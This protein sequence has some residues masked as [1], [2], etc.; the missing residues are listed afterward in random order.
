MADDSIPAPASSGSPSSRT[1]GGGMRWEP[2]T[3]AELQ[4]LMPGYTIEK[5]LG[6]GGMGAV[7]RGV[8]TNLDRTVAIKILPPGVEQEDPSFAERFKNEA[9][10][11]AKLAHPGVV[12]VYDFGST[13]AGQ[14][15][16]VMEYVDGSDV[17]Q[18]LKE[19]GRLPPE[20]A[21][22][23]TAHVLDALGAAHKL[24]IV[25]RDIKPANILINMAGAVKVADFGLAKI[26]DPGG[27]GL[28][29]TGFS[30]GTP[31]FVSPEALMLGSQVD[32]RADLY[33][34]GVMLYQMLTG[35]IPRGA[36]KPASVL[37]STLDPRYDPI[38]TKAMQH[39]REERYQNS[40]EMRQ[41]LDVILT[42]PYVAPEATSPVAAVPAPQGEAPRT[43]QPQQ[44]MPQPARH[45]PPPPPKKKSGAGM[46]IG[47]LGVI[48]VIAAGAFFFLKKPQP[49]PAGQ[50]SGS[51]VTTPS[52]GGSASPSPSPPV[53]SS[54][55]LATAT[56]DAPFINTL[57]MKFV[58]VPITGGPTV[59]KRVI[60][61][62]WET[63]MQDFGVFVK[64][65]KREWTS[66]GIP[67]GPTHPAVNVSWEDAQAFCVWLTERER[68]AG[69]LAANERYRLP[70]DHEWSCAVGIGE[71]EDA[72]RLPSEKY[73]K[74]ADVFPWGSVWPP[75]VGAGNFS[76]EETIGK[77]INKATQISLTGYRD[78]FIATAPVGSFPPSRFGIFD[79]GGNVWEW[80]EDWFDAS[81][82]DRVLRGGSWGNFERDRLL[83]SN[84]GHR[85]TVS[86]ADKQGFR[87]VLSAGAA[88][89]SADST[90]SN[91]PAP[92]TVVPSPAAPAPSLV[93]AT[94]PTM[95]SIAPAA[96]ATPPPAIPTPPSTD[97]RLVQL[98]AGFQARYESDAQKPFLAAVATLNQSYV[99]NGI[100]R[101]RA[102][103]QS[104][105]SLPEVT[106]LDAEKAAIEKGAGV[107]AED[108]ADT[109]ESLKSLRATYRTA[110]AK[111]E[112]DRAKKAAP[113]Y[114]IYVK[115][116]DAYVIELTKAN[117]IEDATK[118]K[119]LR[120]EIATRR[121]APVASIAGG[122]APA[123]SKDGITNT[124]GMKFVPVKGTDVLFCIHETRRQ[125]YAAYAAE[126]P[127]VDGS[128]KN[129]QK[130][131]VPCGDK[132]NHP[133]V[134]VNWEDAHAFCAW[135]SKKEG[136]T[137]RLPT[138]EEWSLAVGL[139]RAEK[140]QSTEFP[141]GGD[142][143]PKTKDQAGNYSDSSWHES[144]PALQGIEDYT[145]GF[146]TTAPVMRFKPNKLG[147][148]DLG[149]NVWEWVEDG[150]A[151]PTD[152]VA[153]GSSFANFERGTLLSS[154]RARLP[155]SSRIDD[156]GFRC[157]LVLS[158]P[159]PATAM[160]PSVQPINPAAA[161][162][163]KNGFTN[164]LGMKF[165]P[166]KGTDVLFCIHET[167]RQDY[168][169]YAAG[170]S[171]VD[172]SWQNKMQE[173]VPAGHEDSHPVVGVSWDDAQAFCVWL[174]QKEGK[175]YRLPTDREWSIA[176]GLG[177]D[178]KWTADTTPDTVEKNPNKFPWGT[179]YPPRTSMRVGNLG[180]TEW[181]AKFPEK[182]F[183][184]DYTD[185]YA[186]TAP[187]MSFEPNS[188]GLYDMGGSV[189]EWV[190][191]WHSAERIHRT[192][193]GSSYFFFSRGRESM[194][195]SYRDK[196]LPEDRS[197]INGFRVVLVP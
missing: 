155:R 56:K 40:A 72:A 172:G 106:A 134:G 111:L 60:F 85:T 163:L 168:A 179:D 15:Y 6:R 74:L 77:E 35:N 154:Y 117:K 108:A 96:P 66:A 183:L 195:S 102:A 123:S 125:D 94:T 46:M 113:L 103:A 161:L 32:G 31:D 64:E 194:L 62:V 44:R 68:K 153:R 47:V 1:S 196:R 69:K 42:T 127:D 165:L 107:P 173:E 86:R 52:Q 99:A 61:S 147:L 8:Q 112:A 50:G 160:P 174:G 78:A 181:K 145:D 17:S 101:A 138:D 28:T 84:R 177:R 71:R 24:G 104:K 97:P 141:W 23:I 164:T 43:R 185:G 13:S 180:D 87:C 26:D 10:L 139:G 34:V 169:A 130:N 27:H 162:V 39:D 98:E 4:A 133:V 137:Y 116:L 121:V 151:A 159:A 25:H 11:M 29:R 187:V 45:Y 18:L 110:L 150:N 128:W 132:D 156:Y 136:K 170:V 36:F 114:D 191:D 51:V 2:P 38:I 41:A 89:A 175:T 115:A 105:G 122:S 109:S 146:P 142:F 119:T 189:W 186:T 166:V 3:A 92:M 37:R 49:V 30:M 88:S 100:A 82:K 93:A 140:P 176:V 63:R 118:V 54:S 16:F 7:Y 14:L 81:Q 48:A 65:T 143:P 184:E 144:F 53:S 55:P 190:E 129:Q 67:R 80:C 149:G 76:G 57:G 33:A 5:L 193:R 70:S 135:L 182:K 131:G 95:P 188:F 19:Q 75:P 197:A 124:L 91:T 158:S 90:V 148:Y 83:S 9:R 126:E 79:L 20:H 178:E 58:P 152:P 157:V 120:E 59:G 12:G 73:G 21:L 167:R 192:L 22:A 171:G